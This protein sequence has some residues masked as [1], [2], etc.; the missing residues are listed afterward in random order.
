MVNFLNHTLLSAHNS[1]SG[2]LDGLRLAEVLAVSPPQMAKLLEV[3][4]SG[5]RKNPDSVKL[6]PKLA[7]ILDLVQRLKTLLEGKLEY[8]LIW[9]KAPHPNLEGQTPLSCLEIGRYDA[10]ETL[11]Y[12][13]ETGQPV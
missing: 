2:R 11:V 6:Q 13:M 3:T 12:A 5:L 1:E 10:V 8:V 4:P 7:E 9:L